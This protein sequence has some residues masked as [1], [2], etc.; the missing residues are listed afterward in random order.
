MMQKRL[1]S[2]WMAKPLMIV[3]CVSIL[4]KLNGLILVRPVNTSETDDTHTTRNIVIQGPDLEIVID[5]RDQEIDDRDLEID[6]RDQ[7][8]DDRDLEIDD[9]AAALVIDMID[10]D[11]WLCRN[12]QNLIPEIDKNTVI[13]F[14]CLA[15]S[16]FNSIISNTFKLNEKIH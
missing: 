13:F 10:D 4:A 1:L 15:S 8:I 9:E 3:N 5:D 6:D 16:E 11:S 7:E 2:V 12:I 14:P